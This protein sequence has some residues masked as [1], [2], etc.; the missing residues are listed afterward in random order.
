MA[1]VA[2]FP[3][4]YLGLAHPYLAIDTCDQASL[5]VHPAL[6]RMAKPTGEQRP[7]LPRRRC[8]FLW[9]LCGLPAAAGLAAG[10]PWAWAEAN[11]SWS[12]VSSHWPQASA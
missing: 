3:L 12:L 4:Q 9:M 11:G 8:G 6:Q 10:L 7:W 2:I 5:L 1:H